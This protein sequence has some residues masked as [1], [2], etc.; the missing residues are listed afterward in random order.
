[1]IE[2]STTDVDMLVSDHRAIGRTAW[3]RITA[4]DPNRIF[5]GVILITVPH[6]DD[7]ALA[8]GGTIARLSDKQRI[9]LVYATDGT[10]APEPVVPW[11]DR[12]TPDLG[13]LRRME[14]IAAM[15]GL[16]VPESNL[17]F[18][19]LPERRLERHQD[20]LR[21]L[22]VDMMQRIRPD[23]VLTPFRYDR[24][25]DHIALNGVVTAACRS[26]QR[27]ALTEYFVYHQW[28]LLPRRDVRRYIHPDEL[29][30]V[31]IGEGAHRKRAA[32]ECFRTQTTRFYS[33]QSR[34][35]LTPQL[36]D[37]V[38]REP[39]LFLRYREDL[40]GAAIF[41][42]PVAWIR[43]AH[44]LESPLKRFKDRMIALAR[45][46]FVRRAAA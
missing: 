7:E 46:P 6:M 21:R 29:V 8:C 16:G 25:R 24:H 38:S 14:S 13:A 42:G 36:L 45:R 40:P 41:N 37:D 17:Y 23:H 12:V 9:H 32:L 18:L 2:E 1:V 5:A 11:T 26:L 10:Q 35:N 22:L 15:T 34:P 31:D 30:R 19:N 27:V 4:E 28:R 3:D 33:W 20:Q 43:V 44:R 39:E